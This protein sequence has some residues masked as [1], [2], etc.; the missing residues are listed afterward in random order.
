MVA[1]EECKHPLSWTASG[2]SLDDF[3]LV[4]LPGGHDKAVRQIL[5]SESLHRLLADYFPKTRKA[6]A[7]MK[8]VA[9]ICH[10]PLILA[11]AKRPDGKS[12]IY[13]C[14]T[15]A[16]PAKME[17]LAYWGTRM[18]LGDYYKTYGAGSENVQ[19]TVSD[20]PHARGACSGHT[21]LGFR[22]H[23]C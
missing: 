4:V 16:L 9:A 20:V 8:A 14:Q 15:T 21:P 22:F 19:D 2:F 10:G 7:G 5:D 3:N 23:A 1:S 17:A 18:F 11:N 13:D 12:V 6:D